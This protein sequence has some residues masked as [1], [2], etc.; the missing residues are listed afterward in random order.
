MP[1]VQTDLDEKYTQARLDISDFFGRIEY[2]EDELDLFNLLVT[3]DFGWGE[4]LSSTSSVEMNNIA[5]WNAQ[6]FLGGFLGTLLAPW[7]QDRKSEN[8]AQEFRLTSAFDGPFQFIAGLFYT[9]TDSEFEQIIYFG[10]DPANNPLSN[11]FD[12]ILFQQGWIP[13]SNQ[14]KQKAIFGEL[15]YD[16]NEKW[17][18]TL[19][20]RFFKY[21][22]QSATLTHNAFAGQPPVITTSLNDDNSGQTFKANL[23]YKPNPDTLLYAQWAEGYRNQFSTPANAGNCDLDGDGILDGTNVRVEDANQL[24]PDETDNYEI[25]AK[26]TRL[27]GRLVVSAAVFHVDWTGLPLNFRPLCGFL[28]TLPAGAARSRGVEFEGQYAATEQLRLNLGLSFID[29]E[30][31]D[32][33]EELGGEAGDPLPGSADTNFHLGF[34]Y[35][36]DI[37]TRAAFINGDVMYVG[38]YY[39]NVREEGLES[40]DYWTGRLAA[41]MNFASF[42]LELFVRNI[43][44]SSAL[45][46][47]E[48]PDNSSDTRAHRLRPRTIG[49]SVRWRY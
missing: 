25:G 19:G 41:G 47:V 26:L 39:N 48:T 6:G 36:F 35:F 23:S 49:V 1:E 2:N 18:A 16:F 20:G 3:Y 33:F 7:E 45:T 12:P 37:G 30:L 46:W 14:G 32:D 11:A 10:G 40:G 29:A 44:N 38:G 43:G 34:D 31:R 13:G 4:L 8:F 24:D 5:E 27:D 28:F 22:A 9:K 42:D 17:Q 15:T 21:D